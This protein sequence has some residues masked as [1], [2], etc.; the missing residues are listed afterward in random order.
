M[1]VRYKV[2][3]VSTAIGSNTKKGQRILRSVNQLKNTA[4]GV[5]LVGVFSAGFVVGANLYCMLECS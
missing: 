3:E 1:Q 2:L 5:S 4:K